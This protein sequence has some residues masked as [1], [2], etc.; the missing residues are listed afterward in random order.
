MKLSQVKISNFRLFVG[1]TIEL[2]K[3]ELQA[4]MPSSS[5]VNV[6]SPG[7]DS[8]TILVGP[9]NC[10]KTSV[11]EAFQLFVSGGMRSFSVND[12]SLSARTK[13]KCAEEAIRGTNADEAV[14][15]SLL[16]M[17]CMD[18]LFEH[19]D[20]ASDL[21]VVWD[22]M[23]DLEE[24]NVV[25]LR[26]QFEVVECARLIEE[27]RRNHNR[28][29]SLYAL[30]SRQLNEFYKLR[31][32]KLRPNSNDV[33]PITDRDTIK[34]IIKVDY[35]FAQ[36]HVDDNETSRSM[37]LSSLL[38][39]HYETHWRHAEPEQYDALENAIVNHASE[40][41]TKYES[42]FEGLKEG[43]AL[44][45]TS[46]VGG[47]PEIAIRAELR[48]SDLLGKHTSV[49]YRPPMGNGNSQDPHFELPEKYNG[50]GYKNLIYMILQLQSFRL[51]VT[52]DLQARPRIHMLFIEEPEAH[53]HP[54]VQTVF[55]RQLWMLL[56][57]V[58]SSDDV[59]VVI[60]THSP[61][62]VAECGFRPIR[63]FRSRGTEVV[64]KDLLCFQKSEESGTSGIDSSENLR[65]LRRYIRLTHCD[66]FFTNKLILVEGA[67]ERLLMPLM[68]AEAGRTDAQKE[69]EYISVIEVGGF[70]AEKFRSILKFLE[71]PT[72]IVTD[73]DSVG[74][75]RKACRVAEG[76][77]SSNSTLTQWLPGMKELKHLLTCNDDDKVDGCI[78]VAY[79]VEE[80]VPGY[81]ARSF[82]EAMI[83]ANLEWIRENSVRLPTIARELQNISSDEHLRDMAYELIREDKKKVSFALDLMMVSGWT[84]PRYIIEG[85][86]WLASYG[87]HAS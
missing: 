66:M 22:L 84:T 86:S 65:F 75:D 3:G 81:C 68:I 20:S 62:I 4:G 1:A 53:L 25:A 32:Y 18:L 63:Y 35:L 49:Y 67:C 83:V 69:R 8:T 79:Q 50:L 73:I 16:P 23:M 12:F 45:G 57:R 40:L 47:L 24:K 36:R 51:L 15:R 70:H 19:D 41:S 58:A 43:V 39:S 11:A 9:N 37:K 54:Q 52:S 34:R 13:F 33:V 74:S 42:S 5:G 26:V 55:L 60:T 82:E 77:S 30:L 48:S 44:F 6:E 59:Q 64:V 29:V 61:H 46:Q 38:H 7:M 87:G 28:G 71:I 76:S 72:L 17:M 10:G 78:K 85:L 14:I 2:S 21:S 56:N 31:Y 80:G 27:F